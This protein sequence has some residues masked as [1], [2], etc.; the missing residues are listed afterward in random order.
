MYGTCLF[1][2]QLDAKIS[3]PQDPSCKVKKHIFDLK[4][5]KMFGDL[6]N[7]RSCS[8]VLRSYKNPHDSSCW[9]PRLEIT[10]TSERAKTRYSSKI[11]A[12]RG[13][14]HRQTPY[15]TRVAKCVLTRNSDHESKTLEEFCFDTTQ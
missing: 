15:S 11:L 3:I 8:T 14:L 7:A 6:N 5:R 13:R 4:D 1:H 9:R 10:G 12:Q 2:A